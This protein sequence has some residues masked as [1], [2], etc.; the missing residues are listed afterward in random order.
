MAALTLSV[1]A[2]GKLAKINRNRI[3]KVKTKE[4]VTYELGRSEGARETFVAPLLTASQNEACKNK[5][6]VFGLDLAGLTSKK[7]NNEG[8]K[9]L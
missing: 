4:K 8:W 6:D 3:G 7:K 5:F 1:S 2:L 9:F